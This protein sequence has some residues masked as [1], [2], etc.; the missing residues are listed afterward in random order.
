[1]ILLKG[2]EQN[3]IEIISSFH[4]HLCFKPNSGLFPDLHW[5]ISKGFYKYF[6]QNM[7]LIS[8][9][10]YI[11]LENRNFEDMCGITR[12]FEYID[13]SIYERT[14][15]SF[16][17][18]FILILRLICAQ[19]KSKCYFLSIMI[20]AYY[21][22]AFITNNRDLR[23]C[24]KSFFRSGPLKSHKLH[25]KGLFYWLLNEEEK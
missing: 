7:F 5:K 14:H 3:V 17:D 2:F 12:L 19:F 20:M 9:L 8:I 21:R 1:M 11:F 6:R 16:N 10:L 25:Y 18:I 23:S 22:E 15:N 4:K 13:N 24:T